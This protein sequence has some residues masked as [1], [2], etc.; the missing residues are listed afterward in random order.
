MFKNVFEIWQ[1]D[2]AIK[3]INNRKRKNSWRI[4][5]ATAT[6]RQ[7]TTLSITAELILVCCDLKPLLIFMPL[8]YI[9]LLE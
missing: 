1:V 9:M 8:I 3:P 4:H 5:N 7:R 6:N 2:P